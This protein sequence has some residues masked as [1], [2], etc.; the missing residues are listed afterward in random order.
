MLGSLH[1][2]SNSYIADQE[3]PAY[4]RYQELARVAGVSRAFTLSVKLGL[5]TLLR[6][7]K[8]TEGAYN[9]CRFRFNTDDISKCEAHEHQHRWQMQQSSSYQQQQRC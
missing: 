3:A 5:Y 2:I 6:D 8:E 1:Q 9:I 4:Q 7:A